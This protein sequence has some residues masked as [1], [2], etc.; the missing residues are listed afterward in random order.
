MDAGD[1]D[2]G[3]IAK[4]GGDAVRL[5][6]LVGQ[7]ELAMQRA[8][9]LAH[10]LA[11]LEGAQ[12]GVIGLQR[13][14]QPGQPAQVG[15]DLGLDAGA[16]N[17]DDDLGAVIKPG[18]VHLGDGAGGQRLGLEAREHRI[19]RRTQ[20]FGE[21]GQHIGPVAGRGVVLQLAELLDPLGLELVHARGQDLA[22]LDEGGAE[23]FERAPHALGRRHVGVGLGV[24][25]VQGV[26]GFFQQVG[27]AHATHHVAKAVADQHGGDLL[28]AAEVS[29]GCQGL[30]QHR[31]P[32]WAGS[33]VLAG[34]GFIVD[35]A[36]RARPLRGREP[37][38]DP[39]TVV[40]RLIW[41]RP[42]AT[43]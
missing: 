28:Q 7:V 2:V 25:P 21:L 42:A 23:L 6:A 12:L 9:E 18:G 38:V 34:Q 30:Q 1:D 37:C 43:I 3:R 15:F 26:A 19:R 8:G 11:R 32:R 31:T 4:V 22:E 40:V 41:I 14:G 35:E 20:V 36:D 17:L 5:T 33:R 29:N 10:H 16:A 39:P 13:G 24:V 27:H